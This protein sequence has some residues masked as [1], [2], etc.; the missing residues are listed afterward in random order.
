MTYF[1]EHLDIPK[2]CNAFFFTLIPKVRDPKYAKDFIPISLIGCQY[3]IIG[4]ILAK[5]LTLVI[6]SVISL[7][8]STFVKDRH[9]LGKPF[10]LMRSF[11]GLRTNNSGL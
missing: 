2:G 7:E 3:K 11:L 8:Q 1:H 9:I 5:S 6:G 10:C 4:K